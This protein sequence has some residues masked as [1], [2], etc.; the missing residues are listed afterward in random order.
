M[1]VTLNKSILSTELI[2]TNTDKKQFS[3]S[4]ALHTY[5]HVS[6]REFHARRSKCHVLSNYIELFNFPNLVVLMKVFMM[7]KILRE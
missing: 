2:I 6:T 7:G 4:T 1:Q 5:F 3:F